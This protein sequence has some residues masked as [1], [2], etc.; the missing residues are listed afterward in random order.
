[1]SRCMRS[2]AGAV[3]ATLLLGIGCSD[4]T[5]MA[6]LLAPRI[7][8]HAVLDVQLR[9]QVV[10][11][12][13]TQSARAERGANASPHD[14]VVSTGGQP[15]SG[16]TVMI[17]G[18]LDSVVATE[19]RR[20]RTNGTG[21]GMYRVKTQTVPRGTTGPSVPGVLRL[22][23]GEHYRLEVRTPDGVVTGSTRLP[24]MPQPADRVTRAFNLDVDTLWLAHPAQR[25]AAAGFF[26]RRILPGFTRSERF[27]YTISDRLLSPIPGDGARRAEATSSIPAH[28]ST[29]GAW[30]EMIL[31]GTAQQFSVVAVDSNYLRYA[32][33]GADMFGEDVPGNALRGGVGLFG[34]VATITDVTLDLVANRDH[35]IEG[36]WSAIG[37]PFDLPVRFRLYASTA[38]P[39]RDASGATVFTGSA[40]YTTGAVW[41][42]EAT[43]KA[44]A[45]SLRFRAP[46][47]GGEFRIGASFDGELLTIQSSAGK[48]AVGYR[49]Q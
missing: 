20:T 43:V 26:L 18:P 22:V 29:F 33:A 40:R 17:A 8:V 23:P 39:Q 4:A 32:M 38:F 30:R 15:V 6:P 14:A 24:D 44:D 10:L 25:A 13:H 19:D 1:M 5:V 47:Q 45:V 42:V 49:L 2:A 27:E 31:P 34:S 12:E 21:A 3:A 46:A 11:V 28:T 7:V 16:A 48:V 37:Q 35:P 41:L 36:E 9:E